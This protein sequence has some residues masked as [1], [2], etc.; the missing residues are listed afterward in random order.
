MA[1]QVLRL[2]KSGFPMQWIGVEEAACYYAK[3]MVLWSLGKFCVTLH[4]GHSRLTGEQSLLPIAPVI[5]IDGALHEQAHRVPKLTNS[6]LFAR[7][8]FHCIYCGNLFPK[9]LLT[10]DHVIPKGHGGHDTWTNCVS[11]CKSCNHHKGCRTPEQA[12][13]P[14]LAVPFKPNKFEYMALANRNILADQMDYLAKGFVR[15]QA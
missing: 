13:M 9:N 14:L 12:N 10:R 7:D 2:D 8:K 11:A 3:N 15:F 1:A 6:A 5:A 4:G